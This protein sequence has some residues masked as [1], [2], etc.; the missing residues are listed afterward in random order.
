MKK[1]N[2]V[3][4]AAFAT[5]VALTACSGGAGASQEANQKAGQEANQETGQK[6]EGESPDGQENVEEGK[7]SEAAAGTEK[8]NWTIEE[9]IENHMRFSGKGYYS[10]YAEGTTFYAAP[11]R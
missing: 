8:A 7:N 4:M 2:F 10:M 9:A 11:T 1:R 6:Q 3:P 5:S